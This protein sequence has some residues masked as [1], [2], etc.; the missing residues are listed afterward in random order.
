[1]VA[2]TDFWIRMCA[3]KPS[4]EG[5]VLR[6]QEVWSYAIMHAEQRSSEATRFQIARAAM[7]RSFLR[8]ENLEIDPAL[9]KSVFYG[10]LVDAFHGYLQKGLPTKDIRELYLD[11]FHKEIPSSWRLKEWLMKSG[12]IR[13]FYF[14][15]RQQEETDVYLRGRRIG[16]VRWFKERK[17]TVHGGTQKQT[18]GQ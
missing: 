15:N 2:D 12:P 10:V 3:S 8:D 1:M 18:D 6:L 9:R 11:V 7:F 14:R 17:I 5:K 4:L 13:R 16:D